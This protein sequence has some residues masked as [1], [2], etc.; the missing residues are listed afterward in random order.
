MLMKEIKIK[1]HIL[2]QGLFRRQSDKVLVQGIDEPLDGRS[3]IISLGSPGNAHGA[4]SI[5]AVQWH[6]GQGCAEIVPRLTRKDADT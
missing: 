4:G 1:F 5:A 3:V 2:K 6:I